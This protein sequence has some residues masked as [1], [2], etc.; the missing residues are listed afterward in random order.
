MITIQGLDDPPILPAGGVLNLGGAILAD[1]GVRYYITG[2]WWDET[3]QQG[4]FAT[5]EGSV[6]GVNPAFVLGPG[7]L[8][9]VNLEFEAA[10]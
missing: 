9:T 1:A 7:D 3:N 5:P 8:V 6:L 10:A 4:I 2:V